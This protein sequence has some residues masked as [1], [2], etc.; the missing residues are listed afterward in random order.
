MADGFMRSP[1]CAAGNRDPRASMP[2]PDGGLTHGQRGPART[3]RCRRRR[4]LDVD[5]DDVLAQQNSPELRRRT[6][7]VAPVGVLDD[8][9]SAFQVVPQ[10]GPTRA[11]RAT[12]ERPARPATAPAATSARR[13]DRPSGNIDI[14]T[15]AADALI[16]L[17]VVGLLLILIPQRPRPCCRDRGPSCH[18]FA[19][20]RS[21][22]VAVY[23]WGQCALGYTVRARA[24]PCA[25]IIIAGR[26]LFGLDMDY[27]LGEGEPWV[28]GMAVTSRSVS[29]FGGFTAT[30]TAAAFARSRIGVLLD[31]CSARIAVLILAVMHLPGRAAERLDRAF[32][33]RREPPERSPTCRAPR[34]H[35]RRRARLRPP[36][37]YR[38]GGRPPSHVRPQGCSGD[39]A[40]GRGR[41]RRPPRCSPGWRGL[42]FMRPAVRRAQGQRRG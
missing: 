33:R 4:V 39:G 27:H 30:T 23:Q 42:G 3:G 31:V 12:G 24:D 20:L 5:Q 29:V 26:A 32:H 2:R 25:L 36:I 14:S 1:C 40:R 35:S 21:R 34:H 7:V 18:L 9:I 16:Y 10:E 6:I 22:V 37:A 38:G 28:H 13:R 41:R 17:A 19:A 8:R 15:K 11:D